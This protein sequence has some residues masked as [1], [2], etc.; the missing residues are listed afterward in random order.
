MGRP[1]LS[2]HSYSG[3]RGIQRCTID[4][5]HPS[6]P[7]LVRDVAKTCDVVVDGFRP[8]VADR[9]GVGYSDVREVRPE[10]IY[11]AATGYGQVGPYSQRVGHDLNYLAM[12][13]FLYCGERGANGLP[14]IPGATVGDAAGGGLQAALAI[15]CALVQRRE[16]Q[17][18]QYLDV[19]ATDGLLGIMS[20]Q[21]DEF[22]ATGFEP[23]PGRGLVTGQFAC[24]AS[25]SVPMVVGSQ[26]RLLR[27]NSLPIYVICSDIPSGLRCNTRRTDKRNFVVPLPASSSCELG[28]NGSPCSVAWRPA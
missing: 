2:F 27:K 13:G 18:G 16:N 1:N 15:A 20:I 17:L 24:T 11:C 22:L 7:G 26:L 10:I 5:K 14:T 6:G 21:I 3:M 23:G 4:L 28:T 8:G 9:L 12:S 19:S 25:T